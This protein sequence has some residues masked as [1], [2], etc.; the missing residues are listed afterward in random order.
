M[1]NTSSFIIACT[2]SP[3]TGG[4]ATYCGDGACTSGCAPAFPFDNGVCYSQPDVIG[5]GNLA[6]TYTCSSNT[7]SG[8]LPVAVGLVA[9]ALLAGASTLA[10]LV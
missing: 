2:G 8:S 7:A 3:P 9:G 10:T 4:N 5:S 6:I 1:S